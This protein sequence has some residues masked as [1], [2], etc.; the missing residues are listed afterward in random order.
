MDVYQCLMW[1]WPSAIAMAGLYTCFTIL[2]LNPGYRLTDYSISPSSPKVPF[3][4][5]LVPL[6]EHADCWRLLTEAVQTQP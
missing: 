4:P 6:P 3:L 5:I 1:T 2:S